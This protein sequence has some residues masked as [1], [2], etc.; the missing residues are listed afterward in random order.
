MVGRLGMELS[1]FDLKFSTRGVI[2]DSGGTVSRCFRSLRALKLDFLVA[3]ENMAD[4]ELM[5]WRET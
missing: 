4:G 2:G 1:R 3:G 5:E